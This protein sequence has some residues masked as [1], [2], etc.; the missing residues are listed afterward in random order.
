MS[1]VNDLHAAIDSV[2]ASAHAEFEKH[3]QAH[4]ARVHE[5]TKDLTKD[6]REPSFVQGV[7]ATASGLRGQLEQLDAHAATLKMVVANLNENHPAD[8]PAAP[9]S[10]PEATPTA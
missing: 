8:T 9:A 10:V 3:A 7:R 5:A 4:E 2:V 6:D 1:L